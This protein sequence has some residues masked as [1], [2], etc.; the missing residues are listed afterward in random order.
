VQN[1]KIKGINFADKRRSLGIARSQTQATEF[2]VLLVLSLFC[3]L[4]TVSVIDLLFAPE[5][6]SEMSG[7]FSRTWR[8]K[9][10]RSLH[11]FFF[12]HWVEQR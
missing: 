8:Y 7:H 10:R 11:S 6:G 4:L 1:T 3:L 5:V 9:D 12:V 2:L